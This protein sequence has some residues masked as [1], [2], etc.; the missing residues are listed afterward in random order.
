MRPQQLCLRAA[1]SR[2]APPRLEFVS[3]KEYD[4]GTSLTAR[5]CEPPY[6][7]GPASAQEKAV[8]TGLCVGSL[9]SHSDSEAGEGLVQTLYRVGTIQGCS[10][11]QVREG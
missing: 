7:P 10:L 3:I 5:Q 1:T 8:L 6:T 11:R 4:T 2:P 9:N